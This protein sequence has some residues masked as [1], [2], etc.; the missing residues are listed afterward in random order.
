M[1]KKYKIFI[2]ISLVSMIFIYN[3]HENNKYN[4]IIKTRFGN[5][6][7]IDPEGICWINP[8]NF[9]MTDDYN[10]NINNIGYVF[11]HG[12]FDTLY[13]AVYFAEKNYKNYYKTNSNIENY[14][15]KQYY[16]DSF[17]NIYSICNNNQTIYGYIVV[18]GGDNFS[19]NYYS[20][21]TYTN[22]I[23]IKQFYLNDLFIKIKIK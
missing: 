18:F 9:E 3:I 17:Y 15:I 7:A 20:I 19:N 23:K 22:N 2:I 21:T 12:Y 4:E 14:I 10:K 5:H 1:K 8:T 16:L 11:Y 6:Y 13:E